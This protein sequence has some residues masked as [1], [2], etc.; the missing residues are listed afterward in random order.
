ME[1]TLALEWVKYSL[2][3]LNCGLF[4]VLIVSLLLSNNSPTSPTPKNAAKTSP[5]ALIVIAHPD[6]E[7]MFFAPLLRFLLY[8]DTQWTWNL[9]TILHT[10]WNVILLCL[11]NGNG[12]GIGRIR[13]KELEK[14][15]QFLGIPRENLIIINDPQLEDGMHT[16]WSPQHIANIIERQFEG[17]NTL[18][19]I[20]TF[21]KVGVSSHPN[22]IAV[23]CGVKL[24]LEKFDREKIFGF[25]LKSTNLARKYIG[26]LDV[27]ISQFGRNFLTRK[28]DLS[29]EMGIFMWKPWW[30]YR[31]MAIHA[32]QF[33]WYR[34][35][36]VIFSRY[37]FLNTFRE[38]SCRSKYQKIE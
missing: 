2:L 12:D 13:E 31:L 20:F 18:Q 17:E 33:V 28:A 34:R 29:G 1:L 9:P 16:K 11:S 38:I 6:D 37:T 30:N 32:S 35:L 24:F 27:A 15:G 21:D 36:F 3:S 5:R 23:Y 10:R 26:V 7:S 14:V 19:A 4:L 22:H 25:A 8:C